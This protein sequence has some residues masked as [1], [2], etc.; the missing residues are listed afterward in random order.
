MEGEMLKGHLDMIVLA[1]L[2]AGPAH[3]YAIIETI[4]RRSGEAVNLP[5]G[6][7][8]PALHRLEQAGLLTSRWV[9]AES[10][11]Q[12]RVYSLSKRGDRALAERR[13]VWQRFASAI[14]GLLEGK[15]SWKTPA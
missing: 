10:G 9:I 1:A 6:T 12:R 4:K 5:E 15:E 11:R 7:I 13:E 8:Y 14:S 3:G 2:A